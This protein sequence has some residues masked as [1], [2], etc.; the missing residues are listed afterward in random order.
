M[1]LLVDRRYLRLPVS[2]QAHSKKLCFRLN[3]RLV[4]DIDANLDRLEPDT[5]QYLDLGFWL[6]RELEV[7]VTP[8]ME[9]PL[10]TVDHLPMERLYR[11][12]YR[13]QSHFSAARGWINDPNGLLWYRGEYHLFFQHNPAGSQWGNMHWGHAV[14]RDLLHWEQREDALFP[15]QEGTVFSGSG[16]VD[17]RNVS[18]LREG[19][20]DPLL[21]FYT[22]A[23]GSSLLSAGRPFTQCLAY[24]T[25]GGSTF[26]KYEKKPLIPHIAGDNRDP[27]VIYSME[28]D[29]YYL[30]LYL[31][32]DAYALFTSRNLLDWKQSQTIRLPGDDECPDFYPLRLDGNG[33]EYWV[34]S[35]ASDRYLVGQLKKG[36]FVPCQPVRQLHYGSCSYASQ[37]FSNIPKEDGRRLRL[38]WNQAVPPHSAFNGAMCTPVEMHLKNLNGELLLCA[39]PVRELS[40]LYTGTDTV[41]DRK[42]GPG[43]ELS[44]PLAGKSQDIRLRLRAE[45]GRPFWITLLGLGLQVIPE[46]NRVKWLEHSMPLY[47]ENG[48]LT[49]RLITDT[50]S[51]EIYAH[52]G[53]AFMAVNHLCDYNLNRL[54]VA[55]GENPLTVV[56]LECSSLAGIWPEE[57]R[58]GKA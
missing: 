32:G 25:D 9:F 34:L 7:T 55:A 22:A 50:T 15:G 26:R 57:I 18:G 21:L 30:A 38:S 17:T 54:T 1:K 40:R 27:K 48:E 6:G 24:S 3:G 4:Y 46:E 51:V 23:G 12:K 36:E 8:E 19:D 16:I 28:D 49:L 13:P 41:K 10:A 45:G 52:E 39:R 37:S 42:L 33:P 20:H 47:M 43:Q 44:R 14:S 35:G 31:E 11:E 2:Y 29:L 5:Y 56:C 53:E 58:E